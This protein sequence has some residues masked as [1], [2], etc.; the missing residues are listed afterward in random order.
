MATHTGETQGSALDALAQ[1]GEMGA[2]WTPISGQVSERMTS[3]TERI[4]EEWERA[5]DQWLQDIDQAT[6]GYLLNAR[7]RAAKDAGDLDMFRW[8]TGTRRAFLAYASDEAREFEQ[9]RP[10]PL[11][12]EWLERA[13]A[14]RFQ[15]N[16]AHVQMIRDDMARMRDLE[17]DLK[18]YLS[19]DLGDYV[20]ELRRH[21][22]PWAEMEE[23]TGKTRK[24]LELK[25]KAHMRSGRG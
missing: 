12:S 16:D 17:A 13:R 9:D 15:E 14:E 10:R 24:A 21:G 20:A 1:H 19:R 3:W 11:W 25:M 5:R 2:Q 22:V 7:G 8:L 4:R 6:H 23:M 18:A